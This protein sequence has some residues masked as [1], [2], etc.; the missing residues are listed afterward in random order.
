M[1]EHVLGTFVPADPTGATS[2]PG[3]WVAGNVS[4]P[5]AQVVVAAAAGLRAAA[6]L[7]GD[8]VLEDTATA[9]AQ[10]RETGT[11]AGRL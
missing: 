9:V 10:R 8:L 3:V 1:F 2:V 11:Y 6:A 4:D 7:N 5:M